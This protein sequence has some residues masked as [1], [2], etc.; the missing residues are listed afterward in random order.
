MP[1]VSR[2]KVQKKVVRVVQKDRN[3]GMIMF[4]SFVVLAVVTSV[5]V[6]LANMWFPGAVVLGTA[7][8]SLMWA[9]F[10]SAIAVAVIDTFATPFLTEWELK[11]KR[12]L[13]GKEMMAVYLVI[14]FVG[15]WLVSRFSEVFGL[16]LSSW[17]VVLILAAVL[18]GVQGVAM[19]NLQKVIKK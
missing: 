6:Y 18:D 8:I 11:R 13:S 5:V 19:V 1:K 4:V 12:D 9:V 16:G 14:N 3:P 10:L 15:L 2:T 17:L 7:N